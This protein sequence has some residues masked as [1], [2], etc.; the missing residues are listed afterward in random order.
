MTSPRSP[1]RFPP[2]FM[3]AFQTAAAGTPVSI[4]SGAPN[5]LKARLWGFQRALRAD[6]Q[7]ELADSIQVSVQGNQVS[8]ILRSQTPEARE[9]AAALQSLPVPDTADSLFDRLPGD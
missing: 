1:S 8:L 2:E 6:G 3:A 5:A 4:P 9:V 7:S